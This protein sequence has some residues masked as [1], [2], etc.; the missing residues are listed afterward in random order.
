MRDSRVSVLLLCCVLTIVLAF[1]GCIAQS[2]ASR[3][4]NTAAANKD[5]CLRETATWYQ[6]PETCY[7]IADMTLRAAC[8]NDSVNP[9]ASQ[10]LIAVNEALGR[11]QP[12]ANPAPGSSDT[13]KPPAPPAAPSSPDTT[14][15]K[16]AACAA[17][18][19]MSND[20]C[21][22]AVAIDL[23]D[24]SICASIPAGD[25]HTHCIFAIASSQKD[26]SICSVLNGNDKQLCSYYSKGG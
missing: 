11:G 7:G 19:T 21:T 26:L 13:A 24:I 17:S 23:Q 15:S 4:D 12:I 1:G 22:Q 5:A 25:I 3:C 14:A 6:E 20:S 16:V 8:L 10:Q 9:D 2:H 18:G